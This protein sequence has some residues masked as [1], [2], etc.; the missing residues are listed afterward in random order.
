V[1]SEY[2]YIASAFGDEPHRILRV[3]QFL[4]KHCSCHLRGECV[5]GGLEA[6][7][8][9]WRVPLLCPANHVFYIPLA[10]YWLVY[11]VLVKRP[12]TYSLKMATAMF[13]ETLENPQ[14]STRLIP[15]SRTGT[16]NPSREILRTRSTSCL[17][18]ELLILVLQV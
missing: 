3:F 15:E 7:Y 11:R 4:G 10:T 1:Y 2:L 18:T 13:A 5:L 14:H 17:N 12:N 16:F 6:S 8:R 9:P